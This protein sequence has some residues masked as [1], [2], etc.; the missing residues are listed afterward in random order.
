MS[1]KPPKPALPRGIDPEL[2]VSQVRNTMPYLFGPGSSPESGAGWDTLEPARV[3]REF[4]GQEALSPGSSARELS[5]FGYFRLCVCS[6]Y[7]SCGTLVPTDV[8]NQIRHKLW[9]AALPLETAIEMAGFV[10]STRKWDFTRVT[11]RYVT[12]ARGTAWEREALPGH[13]GEWFT[14][15]AG[16]YGALGQYLGADDPKIVA[17]AQ[18]TRSRVFAA[19]EDEVHR[20]SEIFGSLYGAQTEAKSGLSCLKASAIVAHNFGD[21]DRVMD[22]WDLSAAD[23]LRLKFYK[24]TATPFDSDGKLRYL[25]RLWIAGELYKAP[26]GDKIAGSSMAFE[27][28]RH[29]ALRKPRCLRKDPRLLV[30]IGPFLDDWG[31][32]VAELLD[33]AELG[34]VVDALEQGWERLPKTVGYGRAL[35]AIGLVRPEIK[36]TR[37]SQNHAFR[38]VLEAPRDRFEKRWN[39]E[40]LR[41]L[42]EIP[43]RA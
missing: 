41:E 42:D 16:A 34:E 25:G 29:F 8:D 10:L 35:H 33:P 40:A 17:Q 18:E 5:H 19:I 27:N 4:A 3:V 1:R 14:I 20:H 24:L 22:M 7:L 9:P 6:H 13:L 28:H 11:T 32:R 26:I 23:P 43:S 39:D 31:K 37:L 36:F 15:A 12:G 2:L 38:A 21:L 30:P